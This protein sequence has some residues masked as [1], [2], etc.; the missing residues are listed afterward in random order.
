MKKILIGLSL[1]SLVSCSNQKYIYTINYS[2]TVEDYTLI[3][4]ESIV[5]SKP[6]STKAINKLKRSPNYKIYAPTAD[7]VWVEEWIRETK[8]THK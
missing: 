1:F 2:K 6:D 3:S 8:K 5:L 4:V 7:S